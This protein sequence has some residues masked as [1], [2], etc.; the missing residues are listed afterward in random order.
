MDH[1]KRTL[2]NVTLG[3]VALRTILYEIK[4]SY[5]AQCYLLFPTTFC[6]HK[7]SR[8]HIETQRAKKSQT[9]KMKLGRNNV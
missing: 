8:I 7:N 1:A 6:N 2:S 4:A 3:D 9:Q 5:G